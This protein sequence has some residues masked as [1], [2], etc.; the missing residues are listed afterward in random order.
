MPDVYGAT[1]IPV[2]A[3]A[4]GVALSDPLLT[5]LGDFLAT[6]LRADLATAMAA[7]FPGES[8][9][10][11]DAIYAYNPGD[12]DFEPRLPALYVWRDA[13]QPGRFTDEDYGQRGTVLALWVLP[14][15]R[16]DRASVLRSI[17][18]GAGKAVHRAIE[19]GRHPSWVVAGDT[20]TFAATQGSSI[21]T[22]GGLFSIDVSTVDEA[23]VVV[24]DGPGARPFPAVRFDLNVREDVDE[25]ADGYLSGYPHNHQV[26]IAQGNA[27]ATFAQVSDFSTEFT[28]EFS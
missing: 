21:L 5:T 17:M 6:V 27:S 15:L 16:D 12:S 9:V 13:L 8:V 18:T 26:T 24:G 11:T 3:P 19:I 22:H 10:R 28:T 23:E 14:G 25:R 7:A 2:Q 4:A 20:E 1:E